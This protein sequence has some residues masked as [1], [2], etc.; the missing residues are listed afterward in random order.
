VTSCGVS[1]FMLPHPQGDHA[2]M[3]FMLNLLLLA[4]PWVSA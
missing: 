3:H 2:P 4:A 1:A